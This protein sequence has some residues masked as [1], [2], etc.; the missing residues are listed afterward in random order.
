MSYGFEENKFLLCI[1]LVIS[2][3]LQIGFPF[4]P[5]LQ[6]APGPQGLGKQGSGLSIH[7]WFSQ[8]KSP[9]QSGSITHSGPQPVIVSGLGT[10][11]GWHL[12]ID[13]SKTVIYVVIIP[14]KNSIWKQIQ[15]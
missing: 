8:T 3:N 12:K 13:K 7:F 10:K 1:Y 15:N 5:T 14:Q 2:T 6:V 11:P 4:G 9:G